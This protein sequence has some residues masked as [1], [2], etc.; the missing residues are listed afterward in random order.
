MVFENSAE[1][2]MCSGGRN[3]RQ[4][5]MRKSSFIICT[6][7]QIFYSVGIY[8]HPRRLVVFVVTAVRA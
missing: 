5:N 2:T 6:L 7:L 8:L 1:E 3:S 4:G